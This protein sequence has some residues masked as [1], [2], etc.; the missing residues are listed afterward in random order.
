MQRWAKIALHLPEEAYRSSILSLEILRMLAGSARGLVALV[1][2]VVLGILRRREI[3]SAWGEFE[4][5]RG[6]RALILVLLVWATWAGVTLDH[7]LFYD[8]SYDVDRLVLFALTGL[9][10]WRPAFVLPHVF[11]FIAIEHQFDYPFGRQIFARTILEDLLLLFGASVLVG[12]ITRRRDARTF[13]FAASV[14]LASY[15]WYPGWVKL[16]HGW[17]SYGRLYLG[18]FASY[19]NGWLG[20]FSVEHVER[21]LRLGALLDWPG[22]AITLLTELGALAFFVH[23]KVPR[24]LLAAWAILH[25]GIWVFSGI[26]FLVWVG[27]DLAF[28]S[29]LFFRLDRCPDFFSPRF[30]LLGAILMISSPLWVGPPA[31]GWFDTQLVY[32]YRYQALDDRGELTAFPADATPL[33]EAWCARDFPF[34]IE[35]KALLVRYGKTNDRDLADRVSALDGNAASVFALEEEYGRVYFDE[36]QGRE[37]DHFLG[38]TAAHWNRRGTQTHL[39]SF[40]APPRTCLSPRSPPE[41]V[42]APGRA[43]RRIVVHQLT[44]LFDGRTFREIRRTPVRTIDVPS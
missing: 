43:A 11:L 31:V 24:V 37:F 36:A 16:T 26:S 13:L 40:A 4:S 6:V 14:L 5:A 19:A 1:P 34:L 30:A 8:Q 41:P 20:S 21:L 32:T 38:T 42:I 10:I 39:L 27:V 44:F 33:G 2:L 12:G 22:R 17:F 9:A 18:G 23:R 28:L 15:Y 35:R 3:A 29:L 7:N 25:I